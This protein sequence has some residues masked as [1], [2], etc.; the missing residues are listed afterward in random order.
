MI[1]INGEQYAE[2]DKEFIDSLFTPGGTLRTFAKITR[3][4]T[5]RERGILY[6]TDDRGGYCLDENS[7]IFGVFYKLDGGRIGFNYTAQEIKRQ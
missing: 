7:G 4:D 1:V 3:R 2:N 6:W 5:K